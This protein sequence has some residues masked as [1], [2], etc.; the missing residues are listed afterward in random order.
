MSAEKIAGSFS[1]FI[2]QCANTFVSLIKVILKSKRGSTLP[3][4]NTPSCIVLGNGPS[5]KTSLEKYPDFFTKHAL[6]CVN[7]FSI[8]EEYTTL[9]PTYY[10]IL[11]PGFWYGDSDVVTNTIDSLIK[12]T[13]WT[14]YLLVPHLA[15]Q[16]PKFRELNKH[17]PNIKINYF[18]YTVY[19]GFKSI[20]YKLYKNN[21][22]MIQSQN[23]LV[24]S[25]FLALNI[26]F[27]EI[28]LFGADHT[29]HETL[30]VNDENI[31]CLKHLHFYDGKEKPDYRPFYKGIHLKETFNMYEVFTTFAKIF[32]GY[33]Q[34]NEYAEFRK[35]KIYN[36]SEVSYIDAFERI[37][38]STTNYES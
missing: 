33:M 36:A 18:N 25:L 28:Y 38:L 5:L 22:A 26:G 24:G 15:K 30:Y 8:T 32:Y 21:I 10:V 2:N 31:V 35:A 4:A 16:S 7:S 27:K 9:K 17:N 14:V 19:R 1:T 3:I 6:V 34:V 20:G 12:K 13:T 23:V 29:W 37:K 11:D